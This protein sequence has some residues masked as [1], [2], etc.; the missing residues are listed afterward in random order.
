LTIKHE[1][2]WDDNAALKQA[3]LTLSKK[4]E[5]MVQLEKTIRELNQNLVNA[6]LERTK[7]IEAHQSRVK[8]LQDKFLEDLKTAGRDQAMEVEL[9]LRKELAK[10]KEDALVNQRT[11]ITQEFN[12]SKKELMRE[13]ESLKSKLKQTEQVSQKELD[14]RWNVREKEIQDFIQ[15]LQRNHDFEIQVLSQQMEKLKIETKRQLDPQ[16]EDR[17]SKLQSMLNK[18]DGEI[19]FL[20]DTVRVECEERMGLVAE[21]S[22]LQS[23]LNTPEER[24]SN[25]LPKTSSR[26]T[27][28]IKP[29]TELLNP[30]DSNMF[31]LFQMASQKNEKRLERQSKSFK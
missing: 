10:D 20:K 18:K 11:S 13:I 3:H 17:I 9:K 4:N 1:K 21:L 28:A 27:S 7:T 25:A 6:R 29:A 31:K 16:V 26:P 30:K 19:A 22:R 23:Q 15:E 8:Q 12:E 24:L 14:E 2:S 5:Q